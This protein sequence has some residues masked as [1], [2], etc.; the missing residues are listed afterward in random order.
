MDG[1]WLG[2]EAWQATCIARVLYGMHQLVERK[3]RRGASGASRRRRALVDDMGLK[4]TTVRRARA[5]S[6][7]TYPC[8]KPGG[9]A[10]DGPGTRAGR[11]QVVTS[12]MYSAGARRPSVCTARVHQ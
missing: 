6:R 12:E 3:R 8:L 2:D 11:V 5:G 7:D 4:A 10:I 1:G 9:R